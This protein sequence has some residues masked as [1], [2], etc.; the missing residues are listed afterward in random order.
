MY[1]TYHILNSDPE[2]NLEGTD[3][4]GLYQKMT[5][6]ILEGITKYNKKGNNF[7]FKQILSLE[8]HT[9]QYVSLGRSSYIELPES[10]AKKKAVINLNNKDNQCFMWAVIRALNMT[11]NHP[12]R[13]DTK[14]IKGYRKFQLGR[15]YLSC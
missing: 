7:I 12:E 11:D 15:Y 2:V 10:L 8:I 14:L 5:D 1:L 4:N 9:V 13:I 6:K 3:V